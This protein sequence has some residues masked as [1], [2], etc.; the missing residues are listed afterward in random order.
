[1]E[2]EA[3]FRAVRGHMLMEGRNRHINETIAILLFHCN[4]FEKHCNA[5]QKHCNALHFH[6][7]AFEKHCNAF[8]KHCN[9]T[10]VLQWFR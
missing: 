3:Y 1:M 5:F 4:A 8:Q 6:C 9:K 2:G 10:G 7:N